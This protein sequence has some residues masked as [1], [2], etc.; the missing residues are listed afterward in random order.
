[1]GLPRSIAD[2]RDMDE[3]VTIAD[4]NEPLLAEA[5]DRI[6]VSGPGRS[7]MEIDGERYIVAA[8]D[9]AGVAKDDWVLLIVV[10]EDDF[11]GFVATNTRRS[12]LLSGG[13][14]FL[15]LLLAGLL[16]WQTIRTERTREALRGRQAALNRQTSA[17][18][19]IAALANTQDDGAVAQRATELG[20]GVVAARRVSVWQLEGPVLHCIDCFDRETGGHTSKAELR[21]GECPGLFGALRRGEE[22]EV[23]DAAADP[24]TADAYTLY[25]QPVGC[26]SLLSVP[27][28]RRQ[29][30]VGALWF[31]DPDTDRSTRTDSRSI[32]RT[33][34]Q[35]LGAQLNPTAQAAPATVE[36]GAPRRVAGEAVVAAGGGAGGASIED[37]AGSPSALRTAS[38]AGERNQAFLRQ[39]PARGLSRDRMLA[40]VFP[41]ATVLVLKLLDDLA[42]AASAAE[43]HDVALIEQVVEL[44]Q[45]SAEKL[46]VRYVKILG[47]QIIAIEGFD[48]GAYEGAARLGDLALAL[49]DDLSHGLLGSGRALAFGM[50]LDTGTVLGAP[51]GFGR[52][53]Y[54]V[55][56]ETLRVALAMAATA[57]PGAIQ[58]TQAT[59]EP[60]RQRY[61]FRRRGGF[62]LEPL[63][64]MTTYTLRGRI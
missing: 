60:L 32:A 58:C 7:V 50:G 13:T 53:S 12:L 34:T 3:V 29:D 54:N 24:R 8:S 30:L 61:L 4:L 16:A 47:D 11:T 64:E 22:I 2:E 31:E 51:V 44:F 15:A 43:G 26:R 5:F 45:R 23:D 28:R 46:K 18:E 25:L 59:Y 35:A 33:L 37:L 62:Y 52:G 42:I 63:G 36:T 49:H 1:V 17:L 27:V 39:I 56:G 48:G 6:R 55:W 14:V 21:E 10:P 38:I 41:T 57:P 19:Q 9:L 40:T 20:A